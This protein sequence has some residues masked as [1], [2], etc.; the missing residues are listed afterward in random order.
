MNFRQ[1]RVIT[2]ISVLTAVLSG[3]ASHMQYRTDYSLC[4]LSANQAPSSCDTHA[5]Q[6][7]QAPGGASYLLSF[8]EFD[9]QGHLWDRQ[10]M[11]KVVGQLDEMSARQDLLMV[12]FVHGWKHSAAPGDKNITT[13][14]EVLARLSEE[15][16]Y[17]S[18]QS[19]RPARQVAGIY[20][21]WRGGSVPVPIVENATFWER[22]NTA[23]K[24]GHGDVSEVL[25]RLEQVK[26]DKDSTEQGKSGT[27]LVVVGHSFGGLVVQTALDQIMASRFVR[28]KGP[29]GTQTDIDGFGNLVVLINPAF[30]AQQFASLSD[31]ST[32]RGWYPPTQLP[33]L[34]ILTS[35]ADLATRYAFPAGRSLATAFENTHE[36]PRKNAVTGSTEK[37]SEGFANVIAVGHFMPYRTHRLYITN[38]AAPVRSDVP[39]SGER[40]QSALVAASAWEADKPGSK[41]PFGS[42]MLERTATSAARNPY[43]NI[44]VDKKLIKD[45]N[46]IDDERVVEFLRQLI[47]ISTTSGEQKGM[48]YQALKIPQA[49]PQP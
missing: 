3:C 36:T 33:V 37:I 6:E 12:V 26:R 25:S 16:A 49:S 45:H 35:E 19:Q 43:L 38:E 10:Q 14:R 1:A 44:R 27:R 21:G 24:V 46:D 29:D 4:K 42:L 7:L 17:I 9:D 41:I 5:I 15:E 18:R 8:V 39:S 30:E 13:F 11:H 48:L 47:M 22:K 32:E 2:A 40:V 28:T 34:A 31:M 23:E 20:L